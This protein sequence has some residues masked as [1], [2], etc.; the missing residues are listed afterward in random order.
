MNTTHKRVAGTT[1]HAA[2]AGTTVSTA[3]VVVLAFILRS[4][5]IELTAEVTAALA[6]IFAAVG[7]YIGGWLAPSKRQEVSDFMNESF[8]NIAVMAAQNQT[9]A[10]ILQHTKDAHDSTE[11]PEHPELE[12]GVTEPAD[13]AS[14]ATGEEAPESDEDDGDL[15][16]TMTVAKE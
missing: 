1:T 15:I 3:L 12:L 11:G 4:Y 5:G 9:T 8:A 7:G 10:S 13:D 6:V 16:A 2:T 14:Q